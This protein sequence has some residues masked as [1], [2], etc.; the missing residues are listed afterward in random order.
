MKLILLLTFCLPLLAEEA[1]PIGVTSPHGE[2]RATSQT[3]ESL[4][5]ELAYAKAQIAA[6]QAQLKAEMIAC[7]SPE[8][9]PSRFDAAMAARAADKL[10][11]PEPKKVP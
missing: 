4:Q 10:K 11:P 1:K 5:A 6:M 7:W 9:L 8:V 2:Q 3:V